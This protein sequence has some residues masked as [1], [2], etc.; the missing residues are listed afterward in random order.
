MIINIRVYN[1]TND[2]TYLINLYYNY[3]NRM[4]LLKKLKQTI[5]NNPRKSSRTI[6]RLLKKKYR[7]NKHCKTKKMKKSK[8][9]KRKNKKT[10]YKAKKRK[11]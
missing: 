2:I 4:H 1:K 10:K 3:M 6:I 9:K 11:K 8:Q 7:K 5:K